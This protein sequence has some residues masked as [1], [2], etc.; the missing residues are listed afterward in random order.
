MSTQLTLLLETSSQCVRVEIVESTRVLLPLD[1]RTTSILLIGL[2]ISIGTALTKAGDHVH[3]LHISRQEALA[4]MII[5]QQQI[6]PH[7]SRNLLVMQLFRPTPPDT[8]DLVAVLV[9]VQEIDLPLWHR[10]YRADEGDGRVVKQQSPCRLDTTSTIH[11]PF[12]GAQ[13]WAQTRAMTM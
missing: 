1:L 12:L 4:T 5:G 9:M 2:A 11:H 6:V 10:R 7:F 8:E 3:C 13:Y